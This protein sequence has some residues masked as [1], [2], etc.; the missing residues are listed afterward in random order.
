MSVCMQLVLV[1]GAGPS[2]NGRARGGPGN[3]HGK[4]SG[5]GK[6]ASPP[7]G[8]GNGR[9]RVRAGRETGTGESSRED[10]KQDGESGRMSVHAT[11]GMGNQTGG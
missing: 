6:Q 10:G 11:G 5:R 4:A 8:W 2:V 1:S 7:A 9:G 3:S